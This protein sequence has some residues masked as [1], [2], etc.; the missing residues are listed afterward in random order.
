MTDEDQSTCSAPASLKVNPATLFNGMLPI[1]EETYHADSLQQYLY[2]LGPGTA[3]WTC[4]AE[5][6][7]HVHFSD[8][9]AKPSTG[10]RRWSRSCTGTSK[11]GLMNTATPSVPPFLS[12][13]TSNGDFMMHFSDGERQ[14]VSDP[15]QTECPCRQLDHR[16][17]CRHTSW[18]VARL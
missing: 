10:H 3:V 4:T 11:L 5:E 9:C 13:V 1:T 15:P 16:L 8:N 2:P 17:R 18:H 12:G 7:C 14:G 6:L